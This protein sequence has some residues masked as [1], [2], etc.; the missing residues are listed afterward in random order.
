[1]RTLPGLVVL[2]R[3]RVREDHEASFIQAWSKI[4]EALLQKGSFGSRLHKGPDDLWYG[5]AQWPSDEARL[6]AFAEHSDPE[7]ARMMREAIIERLPE[8]PLTCVAD[9]LVLPNP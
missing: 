3:W 9:Y 1:M 6:S 5:Y 4:T 7:S 8:I 2:Y